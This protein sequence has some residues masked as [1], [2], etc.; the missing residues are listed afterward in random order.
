MEKENSK[1]VFCFEAIG[2]IRHPYQQVPRH[3]SVS[4]LT[5]DLILKPE[6]QPGLKGL[7][8]GDLIWVI[9]CFHLS[10][11]FALDNLQQKPPHREGFYGV[12]SLCS[13]RRPNPIGMSLV[14]ILAI[15]ENIIKLKGIDMLDGTPVLDIKPY[16]PYKNEKL[17]S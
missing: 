1:K 2:Y 9:F 7:K 12:F 5:G 11:P 4:E 17:S 6:Y 8:A 10:P 14:E 16:I 15:E 3:W 13:P